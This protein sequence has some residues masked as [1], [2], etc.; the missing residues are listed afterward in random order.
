[1][2]KAKILSAVIMNILF[3][4]AGSRDPFNP[5]LVQGTATDGPVLTLLKERAYDA[6]YIFTTPNTLTN[7]NALRVDGDAYDVEITD[8]H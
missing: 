6:I 8:Y 5:E 4:F 7:A 1:V 3:T 2:K